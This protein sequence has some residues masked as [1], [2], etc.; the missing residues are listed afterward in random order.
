[1]TYSLEVMSLF[2][3]NIEIES[4][5]KPKALTFSIWFVMWKWDMNF[6]GDFCSVVEL[7]SIYFKDENLDSELIFVFE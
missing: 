3:L 6:E 7:Q 4:P 5:A 2:F 1:M